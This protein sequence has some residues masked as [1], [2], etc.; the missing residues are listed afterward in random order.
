VESVAWATERRD[1]L[2]GFFYLLTLYTY[3]RAVAEDEAKTR[4]GWFVF[5]VVSYTLSLLSKAAAITLPC[6]LILLDVYPIQRLKGDLREWFRP[7]KRRVWAEKIPFFLLAGG[8]AMAAL[9]AQRSSG[10]LKTLDQYDTFSRIGQAAYGYL[11]Y[12]WKTLIPIPLSPL[13]EL[14][15]STPT[16]NFIFF[17]SAFATILI[18]LSLFYLKNRWPALLACWLYYLIVLSPTSG[19]AQSGP[20]LVAD[21]YSYFACMSW[22]LFIGGVIFSY[23]SRSTSSIS[24]RLAPLVTIATAA[25]LILALLARQ[26]SLVWRNTRTLWQHVIAVTPKSS[27][28]YYNLGKSFESENQ[29]DEALRLYTSAV[30]LNPAYANAHHS[31]ADLLA[32]KDRQTEALEH[33]RLALQLKPD[34][35]ETH[36]NL[37]VLLEAR[38]DMAAALAEF[39]K[40]AQLDRRFARAFFNLGRVFARQGDIQKA[41]DNYREAIRL[42][43]NEVVIRISLAEV[44]ARQGNLAA[45]TDLLSSA[46]DLK[47]DLADA[48]AL[49]ARLLA[50]QGKKD[51][52][53][54][55]YLE[56]VRLLKSERAGNNTP[57]GTP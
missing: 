15:I 5:A 7:D 52:A 19:I 30:T 27:M 32:R 45:A 31:L 55:H 8:F 28:A 9:S 2:S 38:G 16:W 3:L 10:T 6:V 50:E 35:A 14:P 34:D 18:T 48:H 29:L 33:Y 26:Q 1:V 41:A 51:E 49:L 23:C 47:P 25:V 37:G 24:R 4:R 42:D 11:F 39:Q 53:Q 40:A 43:P 57:T 22:P 54:K 21:R 12:L 46:L 44:L 20:Q 56:A 17:A 36:N 13:Y